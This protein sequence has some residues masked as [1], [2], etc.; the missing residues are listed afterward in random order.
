MT[1]GMDVGGEA[2]R[3]EKEIKKVARELELADRKLS[4][5]E[6]V[7]KAPAEVVEKVKAKKEALLSRDKK[8]RKSLGE[9]TAMRGSPAG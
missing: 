1:K 3:L 6:F 8:L 2:G 5:D 9:I 4:N 7:S